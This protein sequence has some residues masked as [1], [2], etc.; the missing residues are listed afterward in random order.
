MLIN[1]DKK[2]KKKD[3]NLKHDYINKNNNIRKNKNNTK[4][5]NVNNN[6]IL[7]KFKDDNYRNFKKDILSCVKRKKEMEKR[8]KI[9]LDSAESKFDNIFIN[10]MGN[11]YNS[12]LKKEKNIRSKSVIKQ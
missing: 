8:I 7:D 1:K 6:D 4:L 12:V 11:D 3:Y 9:L 5:K 2:T 10:I